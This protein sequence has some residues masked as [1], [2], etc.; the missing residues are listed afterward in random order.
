M[1]IS[2]QSKPIR[3]YNGLAIVS[4][5]LGLITTVFPIISILYLIAANGGAGYVQS[6][7]CGIPVAVEGILAGTVSLMQVRRPS[8]KGTWMAI[9]GI[10]LGVLFFP[11]FCILAYIL[12]APYL[13]GGAQ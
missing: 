9:L 8:Q 2:E 11:A 1:S 3:N 7:F 6:L 13:F 4:F 12:Y 10:V 5:V